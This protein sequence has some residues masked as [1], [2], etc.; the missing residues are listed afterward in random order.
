MVKLVR[1][2]SNDNGKFNA[3]LDAGISVGEN[4]QIAVQNLTAQTTFETLQLQI[5]K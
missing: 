2:T 1:L 4:T 3:D 5:E